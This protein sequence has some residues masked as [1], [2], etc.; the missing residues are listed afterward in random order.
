MVQPVKTLFAGS[1]TLIDPT[2]PPQRRTLVDL[3]TEDEKVFMGAAIRI[4]SALRYREKNKITTEDEWYVECI[5]SEL[6]RAGQCTSRWILTSPY[7]VQDDL[8][9]FFEKP[10]YEDARKLRIHPIITYVGEEWLK[11]TEEKREPDITNLDLADVIAL[12][13][14]VAT[15][16]LSWNAQLH[17]KN[18]DAL[19][20]LQKEGDRWWLPAKPSGNVAGP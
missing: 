10:E 5:T 16:H 15:K 20:G 7:I 3:L 19:V 11:A 12:C 4:F 14:D 2:M 8:S 6:V 13:D 1:P 9:P 18:L 17:M